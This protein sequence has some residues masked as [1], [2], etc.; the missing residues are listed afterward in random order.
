[1]IA[2]V[3]YRNVTFF[4]VAINTFIID[5]SEIVEFH[6][7]KVLCAITDSAS[8]LEVN[9]NR[10]ILDSLNKS[11]TINGIEF[12]QDRIL[13]FQPPYLLVYSKSP[14]KYAILDCNKN[15]I[16]SE[17]HQFGK[18]IFGE[19]IVDGVG[20]SEF[21]RVRCIL[22][23]KEILKFNL[24]GLSNWLDGSIEKTIRYQSFVEYMKTHW[25][26]H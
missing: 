23:N 26:A 7:G 18:H 2:R 8:V 15:C 16:I 6:S 17:T 3:K 9:S 5:H 20:D 21:I 11:K 10:I 13:R 25:S 22:I 19:Y 1:M 14:Q 4:D 12:L 24:S